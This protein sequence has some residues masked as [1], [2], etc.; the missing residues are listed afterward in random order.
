MDL[1]AF[2]K[3]IADRVEAAGV[4]RQSA[5]R[6]LRDRHSRQ[7]RPQAPHERSAGLLDRA[8]RA[9]SLYVGAGADANGRPASAGAARAAALPADVA[10]QLLRDG[11][12][13]AAQSGGQVVA[14]VGVSGGTVEQDV[15]IL[16]AG[17]RDGSRLTLGR[18]A[19]AIFVVK[20]RRSPANRYRH[21]TQQ[22]EVMKGCSIEE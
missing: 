16:E 8:L 12:R 17:L 4:A 9:E 15:A 10:G 2:A 7:R 11:R 21:D 19:R 3:N 20:K 22:S 14:G 5:G 6:R 1:L 18:T 13:G